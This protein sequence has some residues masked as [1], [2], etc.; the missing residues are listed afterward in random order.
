MSAGGITARATI[1]V[2]VFSGQH[3]LSASADIDGEYRY[4]LERRWEYGGP[5]ALFV[6]LNPSTATAEI[7]DPTIRREVGFAKRWG[8]GRMLKANIFALRSTDPEAL[9]SSRV[10]IGQRNDDAI[11]SLASEADIVIVCWGNHGALNGRGDRVLDL[12]EGRGYAPMCLGR[13]K[14]NQPKHPLYIPNDSAVVPWR[15]S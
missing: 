2:P 15:R 10:P 4:S 5:T 11:L 14:Q 12:L 7:D 6:G 9:Y 1:M 13:T 3:Y 8:C